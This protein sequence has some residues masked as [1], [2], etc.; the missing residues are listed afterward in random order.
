MRCQ[1]ARMP[2]SC[3]GHL[4]G[5]FQ[6]ILSKYTYYVLPVCPLV[7]TSLIFVE[8]IFICI[9]QHKTMIF[10]PPLLF[11]ILLLTLTAA[12]WTS[13]LIYI[14]C[15]WWYQWAPNHLRNKSRP[16]KKHR[17]NRLDLQRHLEMCRYTKSFQSRYHKSY[18][19]YMQLVDIFAINVNKTKLQQVE[20]SQLL[21]RW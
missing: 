4:G 7:G 2:V 11:Y 18:E 16:K 15:I 19:S 10:L 3:T 13:C 9:S 20:M 5:D 14:R 17:Y 12:T 1:F 6:T 21:W 8:Q